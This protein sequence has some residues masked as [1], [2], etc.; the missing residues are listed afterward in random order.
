MPKLVPSLNHWLD[1]QSQKNYQ[2][3]A[4][5]KEIIAEKIPYPYFEILFDMLDHDQTKPYKK[6]LAD[7]ISPFIANQVVG[8]LLPLLEKEQQESPDFDKAL[9]L[10]LLPILTRHLKY[11][12][13]AALKVGGLNLPNFLG[14]VGDDLHPA[15]Q[16]EQD[17][18]QGRALFYQEQ[19]ALI[20]KAIFPNGKEDLI[21]LLSDLPLKEDHIDLLW[22][23]A[24]TTVSTNL[25]Q[26]LD[27][28][29]EKDFWVEFF[30]ELY[31]EMAKDLE[32]QIDLENIGEAKP[33]FDD[34]DQE[35]HQLDVALGE[36][37]LEAA[38]F[39]EVPAANLKL[40]GWLKKLA[41]GEGTKRK[42][43]EAM[44][45]AVRKTFDTELLPKVLMR[46]MERLSEMEHKKMTKAEKI[47][48]K[49]QMVLNL[50]MREK[51]LAENSVDYLIRLVAAKMEQR[52]DSIENP[53]LRISLKA[54]LKICSLIFSYIIRPLLR[55]LRLDQVFIDY[56][57]G[58]IDRATDKSIDVFSKPAL[59]E[60]L[61]FSGVEAFEEV[62]LHPNG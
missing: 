32:R 12:K 34:E 55:L 5:F 4:L 61:V 46:A 39:V 49:N 62:L 15:L 26:A 27:A 33:L 40:P 38:Q 29:F 23:M 58:M 60:D 21:P 7:W 20:F 42:L 47:E 17:D 57:T 36:F 51:K 31:E 28:L 59:H 1:K 50:K 8:T 6:Q 14:V 3:A 54:Y 11:L 16:G 30:D 43:I 35:I 44:G 18:E 9:L 25:P 19:T 45:S 13:E 24:Q 41:G 52:A 53:M 10:A 48:A 22:E 37:I 56:L 2:I